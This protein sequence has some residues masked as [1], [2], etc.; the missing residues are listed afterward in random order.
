MWT[1]SCCM[2][3]LVP[4]LGIKPRTPAVGDHWTNRGS[5]R[6]TGTHPC[7]YKCIINLFM[8]LCL[9]LVAGGSSC[10]HAGSFVGV[11]GTRAHRLSSSCAQFISWPGIEPVS[12]LW[13]LDSVP[14]DHQGSPPGCL[15]PPPAFLLFFC[16]G[17][18]ETSLQHMGNCELWCLDY[19]LWSMGARACRGSSCIAQASW[20]S[21]SCPAA[22]G[23]LVS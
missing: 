7:V 21:L 15:P 13:Q 20:V 6:H 17:C 22:C 9:V 2:Q 14:L 12:L 8:W 10:H 11:Y 23:I 18:I 3:D 19:L 16:I 5:P 4:L 1:V